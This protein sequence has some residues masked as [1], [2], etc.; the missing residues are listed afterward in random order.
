M[1]RIV[2]RDVA[3]EHPQPHERKRRREAHHD[4]DHDEAEHQKPE[5][6]IA[7]VLRSPPIPRW[8]AVS[9][10]SWAR[11]IAI[12]RDSSSTYSLWA[13]CSSTTSISATS[14]R[15]L[16]HSPVLRQTAQRT[17]S[18]MPCSITSTPATGI[19]A[20]NWYTGG[21]F[22]VTFECSPMAQ[23]SDAKTYPE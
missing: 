8:R 10:I 7:H 6:G 16:G 3:E 20:L 14:L 18:A 4:H 17:I 5:C 9:S 15:R 2:E 11:R 22:D 12:L 21:P 13:S 23:D 1:R 19:I